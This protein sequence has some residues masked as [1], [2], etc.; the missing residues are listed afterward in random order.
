MENNFLN[1][2]DFI[3]MY[4]GVMLIK[5][6]IYAPSI[7]A[8]RAYKAYIDQI[9]MYTIG[10]TVSVIGAILLDNIRKCM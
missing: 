7:D 6:I 8:E 4:F 1:V 2:I 10:L 3:A 5:T 9:N